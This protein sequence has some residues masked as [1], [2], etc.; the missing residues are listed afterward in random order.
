MID[1]LTLLCGRNCQA[2]W[3]TFFLLLSLL[4]LSWCVLLLAVHTLV[5]SV[6]EVAPQ[7]TYPVPVSASSVPRTRLSRALA[8]CLCSADA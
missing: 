2:L 4:L 7:L 8:L 5:A 1:T 3:S 6:S